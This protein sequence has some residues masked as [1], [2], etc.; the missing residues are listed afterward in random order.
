MVNLLFQQKRNDKFRHSLVKYC[1]YQGVTVYCAYT[2]KSSS[3]MVV[4]VYG[5]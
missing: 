5:V 2:V 1:F 4:K 3:G